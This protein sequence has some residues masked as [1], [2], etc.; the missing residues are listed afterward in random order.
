MKDY[1]QLTEAGQPLALARL[2]GCAQA[3]K[4]RIKFPGCF[5]IA[6]IGVSGYKKLR[7]FSLDPLLPLALQHLLKSLGSVLQ[8]SFQAFVEDIGP[9]ASQYSLIRE[10]GN[11]ISEL[12]VHHGTLLQKEVPQAYGAK[13]VFG[14]GPQIYFSMNGEYRAKLITTYWNKI[15]KI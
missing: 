6:P 8:I 9:D 14:Q 7:Q 11:Q 2:P 3:G 15:K 1:P 5:Q 10:C 4:A 13:S 12:C